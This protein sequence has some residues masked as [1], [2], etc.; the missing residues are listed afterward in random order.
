MKTLKDITE[1]D[2]LLKSLEVTKYNMWDTV[3]LTQGYLNLR[4]P[5]TVTYSGNTAWTIQD[6][7]GY[8]SL[9]YFMCIDKH[10]LVYG[11]SYTIQVVSKE[12]TLTRDE[13]IRVRNM[14]ISYFKESQDKRAIHLDILNAY[15]HILKESDSNV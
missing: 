8:R 11:D 3:T 12:E 14:A 7:T 4:D 10:S 5:I 13:L 15:K 9:F 2:I 1:K 6:N